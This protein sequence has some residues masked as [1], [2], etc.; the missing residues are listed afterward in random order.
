[1]VEVEKS[2]PDAMVNVEFPG[3][4]I[5]FPIV[6][7]DQWSREA[8]ERYMSTTRNK[9]VY[10]PSNIDY[11]ARNNGLHGGATEVLEKLMDSSWVIGEMRTRLCSDAWSPL[12]RVWG[13]ILFGVSVLGTG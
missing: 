4:K 11:L 10:L 3:R 13:R 5:V 12:A 7:D 8:L 6:L 9:A 1:M 2:L